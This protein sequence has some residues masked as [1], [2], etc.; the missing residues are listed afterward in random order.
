[1]NQSKNIANN[2][3]LKNNLSLILT[4]ITFLVVGVALIKYYQ[5]Q[6]NPDALM[7]IKIDKL[8]ISGDYVNAISAYWGPFISWL[9]IPFLIINS[10]PSYIL[11]STK[12]LS[13]IVGFFTI[14]GISKLSYKFELMKSLEW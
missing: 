5:Y 12:I 9:L 13:L 11:I 10:N 2:I 14:I 1:M 3:T 4:S 8:Y 7:Y 6:I